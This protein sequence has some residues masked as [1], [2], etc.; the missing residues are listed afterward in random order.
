M[1]IMETNCTSALIR[2]VGHFNDS[3]KITAELAACLKPSTVIPVGEI[4][5]QER[6]D[7]GHAVP[8]SVFSTGIK[9]AREGIKD[10]DVLPQFPAE[11]GL[12][13]C[14]G[15][16]V[17]LTCVGGVIKTQQERSGVNLTALAV[18]E[19]AK[20]FRR[21]FPFEEEPLL[22]PF[23]S[24]TNELTIVLFFSVTSWISS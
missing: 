10:L 8:V 17:P 14:A 1:L 20:A 15:R 23:P 9:S 21:C 18:P 13:L 24:A 16:R 2:K 4:L 5:K 7:F 12:H 3:P 22:W 11:R 19:A 6:R